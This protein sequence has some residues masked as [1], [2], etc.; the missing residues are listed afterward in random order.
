MAGQCFL[1]VTAPVRAQEMITLSSRTIRASVA[2]GEDGAG[3]RW[4]GA[5]SAGALGR[6]G[7][8]GV[9]AV[10]ANR[11]AVIGAGAGS[12]GASVPSQLLGLQGTAAEG[13]SIG[14]VPDR[15]DAALVDAAAE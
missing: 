11:F 5:L 6:Q 2:A 1:V 14:L 13:A 10:A 7:G 12:V 4:A 9:G 3:R 8:T 15:F